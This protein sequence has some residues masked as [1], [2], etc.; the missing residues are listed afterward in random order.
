[1]LL[2]LALWLASASDYAGA[3]ACR[4]CHPTQYQA[5][6]SN[7]HARALARSQKPQPGEWAFGAGV[8]A[9]TFVRRLDPEHY[10]E[11]GRSWYR[12]IDGYA[13]T[14]GH[15]AEAGVRDRIFDPSAAILRCFA[16]HYSCHF[17]LS[18]ELG[19]IP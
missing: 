1:M 5:E 16:C 2:Q 9:I 12:A 11:E 13:R 6:S 18:S 19:I 4:G 10:L 14:P 8:Q 3:E 15:S 17:R 7:A